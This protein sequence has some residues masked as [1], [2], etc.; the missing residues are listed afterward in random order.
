[1]HKISPLLMKLEPFAILKLFFNFNDFE[2][3]Y[4]N[5]FYSYKKL[6][7]WTNVLLN[8]ERCGHDVEQ[9]LENSRVKLSTAHFV[10]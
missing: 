8:Q 3:V 10:C 9:R 2:P 7:T 4:S 6:C 1:M 5:K